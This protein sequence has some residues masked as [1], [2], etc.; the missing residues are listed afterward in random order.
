MALNQ[1]KHYLIVKVYFQ[2]FM[3][4]ILE[5][6]DDYTRKD[7][8]RVLQPKRHHHILEASPFSH[9]G[10]LTSILQHDLHLMVLKE[11]ISERIRFL[12]ANIIQDLIDER[13]L[14]GIMHAGIIQFPEIYAYPYFFLLLLFLNHYRAYPIRF[15]HQFNNSCHEHLV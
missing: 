11:P 1:S 4:Y 2:K 7:H 10:H 6:C 8:R 9:E 14:E 13:S 5:R 12:A 3:N 15:L